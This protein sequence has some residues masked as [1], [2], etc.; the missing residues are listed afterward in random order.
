MLIIR[1]PMRV[2][3]FGG[4]TDYP[5]FFNTYGG[6]VISTTIKKYCYV[7]LRNLP[8]L[9]KYENQL[10]YSKIEYFN[11]PSEVQHPL[12]RAA[13]EYMPTPKIQISYD[14][15][16]P[17]CAGLGS[18]SAFAVGL[19][20][21]LHEMRGEHPSPL[22]L[23]KEAIH[24]ERDMCREAGGVQDQIAVAF[25]GFNRIDFSSDGYD[26]KRIEMPQNAK[27]NLQKNLLLLF[28]GFTRFAGIVSVEQKE[29]LPQN[30][31][32]LQKMQALTDTAQSLLQKG[33]IDSFGMLLND[34]WQLKRTLSGQITNEGIDLL[35]NESLE[36]GALGGKLL[37]AGGGGFLLVYVPEEKQASFRS[38]FSDYEIMPVEFSDSG[39][40]VFYRL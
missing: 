32:V 5:A 28:T 35:Y 18:S 21:G 12:V 3:F 20:H 16:M 6:A 37:G 39:S 34:T 22:T 13:L 10:T 27:E 8:P 19:L 29:K 33:D 4:G 30:I 11:S 40:D 9:F 24:L 23:A 38:R 31:A 2:S 26:V 15:D 7:T 36:S 14:A 1:T 25:G 17:A